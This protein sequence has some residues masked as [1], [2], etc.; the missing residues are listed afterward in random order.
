[1]SINK[2][3]RSFVRTIAQTMSSNKNSNNSTNIKCTNF[4]GNTCLD[5]LLFKKEWL[6]Y[7]QNLGVEEI[8]TRGTYG[9]VDFKELR[10]SF[11]TKTELLSQFINK[12]VMLRRPEFLTNYATLLT[13]D[14]PW[15]PCA[16]SRVTIPI[17]QVLVRGNT[18]YHYLP[19]AAETDPVA[20]ELP[21]PCSFYRSLP[22]VPSWSTYPIISGNMTSLRLN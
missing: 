21:F 6:L 16:L 8:I 1:M 19:T 10:S 9:G 17:D 12:Q 14:Y 4:I 7:A 22:I 3:S 13:V 5:W 18:I 11:T 2:R 20:V 15:L